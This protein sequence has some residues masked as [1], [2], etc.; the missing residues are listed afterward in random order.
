MIAKRKLVK[1]FYEYTFE[2]MQIHVYFN[3]DE[4]WFKLVDILDVMKYPEDDEASL[5]ERYAGD[6]I[7]REAWNG[8]PFIITPLFIIEQIVDRF[9]SF[10]NKQFL[11]FIK[12]SLIP[13]VMIKYSNDTKEETEKSPTEK[14][15][16]TLERI[17]N[18]L[19]NIELKLDGIMSAA[20]NKVE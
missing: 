1:D 16:E 17:S 9:P 6:M 15:I 18:S 10:Y 7:T 2:N 8:D 3:N 14:L 12:Y 20:G 13:D 11:K 19:S 5:V 4:P